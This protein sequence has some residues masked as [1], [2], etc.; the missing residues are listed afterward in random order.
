MKR[1][2]NFL[3]TGII[4]NFIRKIATILEKNRTCISRFIGAL[5]FYPFFPP[6][7][8]LN[9]ALIPYPSQSL[10]L[11][12]DLPTSLLFGTVFHVLS[13]VSCLQHLPLHQVI[14]IVFK[15]VSIILSLKEETSSLNSHSS[16]ANPYL[17]FYLNNQTSPKRIS[18]K[19]NKFPLY[20]SSFPQSLSFLKPV[21]CHIL[22]MLSLPSPNYPSSLSHHWPLGLL[23]GTGINF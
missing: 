9:G 10:P 7:F 21:H 2:V 4:S 12:L 6:S 3:F 1:W 22:I 23:D 8:L 20:Q 16:P 14:P 5:L 13:L 11:C 19:I 15:H 17:F 18:L